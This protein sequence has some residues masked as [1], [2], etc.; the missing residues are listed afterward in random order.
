MRITSKPIGWPL[1]VALAA[2]TLGA[3]PAPSTAQ[4]V[5]ASPN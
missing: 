2:A 1:A 3:A 5:S 4:T